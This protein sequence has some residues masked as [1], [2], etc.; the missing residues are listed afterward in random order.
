MIDNFSNFA[1]IALN[2][3]DKAR[4]IMHIKSDLLN[5]GFNLKRLQSYDRKINII[6][7]N[8]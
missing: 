4:L 8:A 7:N 6:K 2:I 3:K 1:I 5:I